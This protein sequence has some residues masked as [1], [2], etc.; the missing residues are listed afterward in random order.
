MHFLNYIYEGD[1]NIFT[2]RSYI[3]FSFG[4]KNQLLL[5]H[6]ILMFYF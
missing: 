2:Y 1:Y 5:Y 4:W 6:E 3:F